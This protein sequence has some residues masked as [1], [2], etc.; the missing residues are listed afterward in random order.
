MT[1]KGTQGI[2]R[3]HAPSRIQKLGFIG[4]HL[5]IV[6]VCFWLVYFSGLTKIGLLF[7]QDWQ[8]SN[9]Q[10]AMILSCCALVYWVR[11]VITLFYLLKRKVSWSEAAG[12]LLFFALF[13]VGLL[14]IGGGAFSKKIIQL[15]WLDG[16]AL[17][18]FFVGS[19]LNSYSEMQRKWWKDQPKNKGQCYTQG[20][21]AYAMHINF[22]GDIVLFTGWCLLTQHIWTLG[23]PVFMTLMFVFHHI[24]T[25]DEY[26]LNRYGAPF[27]IYQQSVKKLVPFVY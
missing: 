15:N 2:D 5:L 22:F 16:L 20:L 26:L 3:S 7:E 25:L 17:V 23:L 18:L 8:F 6:C 10:R 12:L 1:D 27:K 21:F 9:L 14:L 11:H 24:P 13:E 4:V 19:F